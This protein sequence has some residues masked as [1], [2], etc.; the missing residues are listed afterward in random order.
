MKR[1]LIAII[2]IM[3]FF[4]TSC[5]T[6]ES[7]MG[8]QADVSYGGTINLYSVYPDT[9]NPLITKEWANSQILMTVYEGLFSVN[10]DKSVT[11][12]L[13]D[14]Y[15]VDTSGIKYTVSLKKGIVF[16]NGKNFTAQDVVYTL[17][18]IR[19]YSGKY[20]DVSDMIQ[21]FY[22]SDEYE[23][24]IEL[25]KP[26]LNFAVYLD[27]PVIPQG[28][29]I[30]E[31]GKNA[32]FDM[33]NKI[34]P[35]GTGAFMFDSDLGQT[36]MTLVKNPAWHGGQV[37]ADK[38]SVTFMKENTTAVYSFN[39]CQTDIISSDIVKWGEFSFSNNMNTYE[40]ANDYYSYLAFN[41]ENEIFEN[42]QIRKCISNAIDKARIVNDVMHTHAR[43]VNVPVNP[44][45]Y[46]SPI[47]YESLYDA[48]GVKSTLAS[49]GWTDINADSYADKI[50]NGSVVSL[51]FKMLV[52][53]S[54]ESAVEASKIIKENLESC[55]MGVEIVLKDTDDYYTALKEGDFDIA[56][57]QYQM[58]KNDNISDILSTDGGHNYYGYSNT[59]IDDIL[60]KINKATS[61][62][63]IKSTFVSFGSIFSKEMPC[64]PLYYSTYSV[65]YQAYLKNYSRP[66]YNNIYNGIANIYIKF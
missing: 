49:E 57:I 51:E 10:P 37:Y 21:S 13:S 11:N 41:F 43:A 54:N 28:Y 46:Y 32:F 62:E 20:S 39:S 12:V 18:C 42:T 26:V 40:Y 15:K 55:M 48:E 63:D 8:G 9:F 16:H 58:P 45:A 14:G 66:S 17:G 3:S 19:D 31:D 52:L 27:F 34:Y 35:V 33:N 29:G 56:L 5:G 53:K 44:D 24:V 25:K 61:A 6:G 50:E 64:V 36:S 59:E 2:C 30:S 60:E 23:V 4:L 47:E 7:S 22:A 1:F 65:Y 38:I